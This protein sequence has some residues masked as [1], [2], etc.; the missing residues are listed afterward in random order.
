M[1]VLRLILIL[2]ALSILL[3]GGMYVVTRNRRYLRI[4]WQIVY[5]VIFLVLI[6]GLLFL[7]E[8]YV[9]IGWGILV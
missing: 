7:L 8:R 2:A 4:V 5:L 6:F 9:L 3:S 1:L